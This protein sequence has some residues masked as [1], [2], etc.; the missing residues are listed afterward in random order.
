MHDQDDIDLY[1]A[2][3]GGDRKAGSALIER[4]FPAIERFFASKTQGGAADDLVQQTF[5]RCVQAPR[6]SFRAEGSFRAF[7][8]GIAKNVLFEHIRAR[9]RGQREVPDFAVST[10]VDLMPGASTL[11]ARQSETRLLVM[12][13]QRIPLELQLLLELYYWE[14]MPLSEL[15]EVFEVPA[16]TIKSRL[17]RARNLVREAMEALPGSEDEQRGARTL[18][19]SWLAR[20]KG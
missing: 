12:A 9:T 4:H 20:D 1:R 3:V 6:D 8:F 10:I 14:E 2:W 7:L 11:L 18:L 16:G 19:Q 17:F 15:A 13:L 5:L